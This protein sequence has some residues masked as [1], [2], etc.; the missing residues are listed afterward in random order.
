[1][2]GEDFSSDNSML[3]ELQCNAELSFA[4]HLFLSVRQVVFKQFNLITAS[5]NVCRGMKMTPLDTERRHY[6]SLG[7]NANC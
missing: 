4:K 2:M 5:E 6:L 3:I 1:M 7:M